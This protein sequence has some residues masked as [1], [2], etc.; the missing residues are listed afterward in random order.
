MRSAGPRARDPPESRN[1]PGPDLVAELDR[2]ETTPAAWAL[3]LV[4]SWFGEIWASPDWQTRR[5]RLALVPGESPAGTR[6]PLGSLSWTDPDYAGEDSYADAEPPLAE[7]GAGVRAMVVDAKETPARTALVIEARDGF[8]H[9]FLP[10]LEKLEAFAELLGVVDRAATATG[11]Q[12]HP[13]G[14]RPAA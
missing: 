13:R 12:D 14:L 1:G 2:A 3:P 4:P 7:A 11:N 5:G 6:L 10:P 8:V 9:V